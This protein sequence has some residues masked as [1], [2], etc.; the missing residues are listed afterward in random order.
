M[1][2]LGLIVNPIAGMGGSVGLKGTDGVLEEAVKRGSLPKASDKTRIAVEQLNSIKDK[3]EIIT[4]DNS[5]GLNAI[6]GSDFKIKVIYSSKGNMTTSYDTTEAVKKMLDEKVDLIM[7]TGGDGTARDIYNGVEEKITVIGIPAGVKI[8]S[9]VFAQAPS[10]AG[11]LARLYLEG[12]TTLTN[13]AEVLDIDEDE[14]RK[15]NVNTKLYGYMVVPVERRFMQDKKAP[16]PLSEKSQQYDIAAEVIRD[17]LPDIYYIIGP[18]STTRAIMEK[19]ELKNTLI[20]MDIICNKR[21]VANDLNEKQISEFVKEKEAKL[22]ITPTGGQGFL[23]GRGN[24]Q[25]SPDIIKA[26]GKKNIIVIATKEKIASL[27]GK[28]LLVD[29]GSEKAGGIL[30]GYIKITTGYR[31]SIIYRISVC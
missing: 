27:K 10:K 8:H 7:F 12:K 26:I 31:E 6:K 11:E 15:G 28:P 20:G 14:Y 9:P 4:C 13:E 25:I 30:N 22:I 23:L 18:G 5:M 29:I 3:I 16:S 17:M 2:K 19:L 24:Q 1:K 21:L